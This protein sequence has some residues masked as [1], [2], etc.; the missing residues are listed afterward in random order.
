M[1]T[2]IVENFNSSY[3]NGA[4]FLLPKGKAKP[5][6]VY[7]EAEEDIAFWRNVLQPYEQPNKVQFEI[8]LPINTL[9]K[10]K[11]AA[12]DRTEEI[13]DLLAGGTGKF[14]LIAVDSDY[15]YLL[16][17]HYVNPDKQAVADEIA[18]NKYI[19]QT[20]TYSIENFRCYADS[21]H[22]VVVST[23]LNDERLFDYNQ[24]FTIYSKIIY[25]LLLWNLTLYAN[26]EEEEFT[27][28]TL[29][30]VVALTANEANIISEL[31]ALESRVNAKVV[32]LELAH[33]THKSNLELFATAMQ[34]KGLEPQNAYLFLQGHTLED[35]VV[36]MLLRPIARKLKE[37]RVAAIKAA[38]NSKKELKNNI[39]YY[40]N[41]IGKKLDHQL[42]Q[43]IVKNTNF[44]NCY[45]FDK[46]ETDI[47][48]IFP[49]Y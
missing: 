40:H 11:K 34:A 9:K 36:L 6:P 8:R 26:N 28:T 5:I 15:D 13:L 35:K 3:W 37:E 4:S 30:K 39:D 10:G 33:G 18:T 38:A 32:A 12:L 44:K 24:I 25:P 22:G 31:E 20:Y 2:D 21:L 48:A 19:L 17:G 49:N 42:A 41:K 14:L 23:V 47:A 16:Q 46:I 43:T 29:C 45:L 7:V 1:T 27:M